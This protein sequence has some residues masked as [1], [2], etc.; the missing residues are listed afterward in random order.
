MKEIAQKLL[1]SKGIKSLDLTY[2]EAIAVAQLVERGYAVRGEIIGNVIKLTE[3][4]EKW[5]KEQEN[6]G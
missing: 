2:D 5:L 3:S 1:A 4:G 6:E